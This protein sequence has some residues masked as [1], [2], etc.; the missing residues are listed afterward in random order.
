MGTEGAGRTSGGTQGI[1][2]S[3]GLLEYSIE[4]FRALMGTL[5]V[6]SGYS[7]STLEVLRGLMGYSW[8]TQWSP[9]DGG[10]SG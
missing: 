10:T 9:R 8:G 5:P 2:D 7:G 1:P 3:G 6:L 4:Y